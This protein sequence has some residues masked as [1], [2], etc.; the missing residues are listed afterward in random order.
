MSVR[1]D[2]GKAIPNCKSNSQLSTVHLEKPS[3][4][5]DEI[6]AMM[7][8]LFCFGRTSTPSQAL[9]QQRLC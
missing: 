5:L 3:M 1:R 7:V 6:E 8:I 4:L 9:Y 2:I